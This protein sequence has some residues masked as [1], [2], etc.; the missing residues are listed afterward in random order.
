MMESLKFLF[1][2]PPLDM[3]ITIKAPDG[4]TLTR[5][6]L[7]LPGGKRLYYEKVPG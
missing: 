4:R 1:D 6:V 3:T 2:L 7:V 5:S